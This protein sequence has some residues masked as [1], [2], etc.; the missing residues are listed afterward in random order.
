[1][2]FSTSSIIITCIV[3][4]ILIGLLNVFLTSKSSRKFI[5]TDVVIVLMFIILARLCLPCE[6]PFTKTIEAPIFMNPIANFLRFEI[7]GIPVYIYLFIIWGFGSL[8]QLIRYIQKLKTLNDVFQRLERKSKHST[9]S[10]LLPNYSG[11]DYSV[12]I[13]DIV[14]SPMVLGSKKCIL[15]PEN[16][17]STDELENIL[18]H[19]IKHIENHDY[20]LKQFINL[21]TIAY[22]WFYPVYILQKKI[23]LFIEVRVDEQLTKPMNTKERLDYASMLV[24][25]QKNIPNEDTLLYKHQTS[26]LIDDNSNIL[27]YRVQYLIDD[28]YAK[29][30]SY[31]LIILLILLPFLSNSIVFEPAFEPPG[32]ENYID[33]RDVAERGCI[34]HQKDG[35]Y[36]VIVDDF[37]FVIKDLTDSGFEDL[38]IIEEE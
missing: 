33:A 4:T 31:V 24:K 21:L 36:R 11:K 20:Y 6:L 34:I 5:R 8:I 1:M 28:S 15:L 12:L 26:F 23:D 9:V 10:S 22:W 30:T 18:E 38:E 25:L 13:S 3:A 35:T 32:D 29:K 37:D 7:I 2:Y 27:N 14:H 16:E 19:E 17:Y